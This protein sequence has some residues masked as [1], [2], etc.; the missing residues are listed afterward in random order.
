MKIAVDGMGGDF[1][2]QAVVEGAVQAAREWGIPILLVG[3]KERLEYELSKLDAEGL[4]ISIYHASEVVGMHESPSSAIRKKRDS[5]IRV[6]FELVKRGEAAGVVSAGNSGAAMAVGMFVL[7]K[8]KGVDRPAIAV[9]LPTLKGSAIMLDV[10]GNVDCK[11]HHLFQFALMGSVYATYVLKK[12][13]PRVG[14]LSNGS[15]EGKGDLLTK[16][17]HR[18]L[19]RCSTIHYIGYVEGRDI[20]QGDVDVVVC[21]GFVGNVALK[22]SEGVADAIKTMLKKEVMGSLLAQVGFLLFRKA[23]ENIRRRIDYAEYGGAPLLGIDGTCIISHGASSPKALKNA[24]SLA[25]RYAREQ[26]NIHLLEQ[27]EKNRDLEAFAKRGLTVVERSKA[28]R[29]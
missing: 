27:L 20:Y 9:S 22:V 15:E 6:A 13:R 16:E 24:I 18:I 8:L 1:A 19:K 2:P 28:D 17:T 26:V 3:D 7:K 5:S 29:P 25:Y 11:P 10:G 21:D 14:L 4:P 23:F 12:E